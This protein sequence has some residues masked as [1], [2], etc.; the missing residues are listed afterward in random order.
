M[1]Y[2]LFKELHTQA[3]PLF[4]KEGLLGFPQTQF[5]VILDPYDM[6]VLVAWLG[7]PEN[8]KLFRAWC[9]I[10]HQCWKEK[11]SFPYES[12]KI[13]LS[14]VVTCTVHSHNYSD[15]VS[16]IMISHFAYVFTAWIHGL[17]WIKSKYYMSLEFHRNSRL[18]T[19]FLIQYSYVEKMRYV[20]IGWC[21][22]GIVYAV[23]WP[24]FLSSSICTT[25]LKSKEAI[26][27]ESWSKKGRK[28]H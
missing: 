27:R 12:N 7:D 14:H 8:P 4:W 5:R 23:A 24:Y 16:E 22:H 1:L 19:S 26:S 15:F 2:L 11:K 20:Y 3:M 25:V 21:C 18:K 9:D 13:V 17:A 10:I 28:Q 6:P